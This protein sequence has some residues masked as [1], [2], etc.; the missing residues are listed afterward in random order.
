MFVHHALARR[1]RKLVPIPRFD[2]RIDEQVFS[3][4]GDED[5]K[6]TRLNSS[7][8]RISYA[9]FCLEP[10]NRMQ[11]CS[12]AAN[13]L[14]RQRQSLHQSSSRKLPPVK[15]VGAPS[16]ANAAPAHHRATMTSYQAH[17]L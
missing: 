17:A 9:V 14:C 12:F 3:A 16:H 2:E 10:K 13:A 8:V 11:P 5:R 6:S 7:H 1:E 4:A 15:L